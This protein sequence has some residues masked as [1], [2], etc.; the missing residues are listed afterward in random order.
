MLRHHNKQL[1]RTRWPSLSQ[2]CVGPTLSCAPRSLTKQPHETP[3][4]VVHARCWNTDHTSAAVTVHVAGAGEKV[5]PPATKAAA[6][7]ASKTPVTETKKPADAKPRAK[8]AA[9]VT[10]GPLAGA[11]CSATLCIDEECT[12]NW[13]EVADLVCRPRTADAPPT[14][15]P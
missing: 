13:F 3:I 5:N 4:I 14:A 7:A 12:T 6:P 8:K 1:P 9:S 2:F 11:N 10:E 15:S